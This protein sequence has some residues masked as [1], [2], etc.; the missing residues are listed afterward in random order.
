MKESLLTIICCPDCQGQ[1]TVMNPVV[2]L[3]GVVSGVLTCRTCHSSHSIVDGLPIIQKNAGKMSKT[4]KSFGQQWKLQNAGYFEEGTIFGVNAEQELKDFEVA[5]ELTDLSELHGKL[6]LDAGCGS[7]RLT[8]SIGKAAQ[9]STIIGFDISDSA[10]VA[11]NRC[12][13]LQNVHIL[14]CDL[15]KPPFQ[16]HSFDY[17]YSE[18]VL[19]HTPNTRQSFE[20][21]DRLLKE[22]GK[23]YIWV[24]PNYKFNPFRF[25]RSVL[26]KPYFLPARVLYLVS[27]LFAVPLYCCLKFLNAVALLKRSYELKSLVFAFYDSLSPEFQHSH[28]REEVRAWFVSR[29]YKTVSLTGHIGALGTK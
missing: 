4:Q 23:L 21:L 20:S 10:R 12:K 27:W 19:H 8:H 9:N 18:G 3:T 22:N 29:K 7:G 28:S 14:Q 5:F 16:D 24:Y 17:I 25:V 15:L 1:L 11:F 2:N 26:Y 6:V 13:D